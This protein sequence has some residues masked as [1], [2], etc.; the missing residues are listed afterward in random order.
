MI[1]DRLENAGQ[2]YRVCPWLGKAVEFAAKFDLSSTDG[3]YEVDGLDMYA[4]VMTYQTKTPR[5]LLFEVHRKYIDLQLVLG[6]VER[7]DVIN[8]AASLI[9]NK[10]YNVETDAEFYDE[11]S[12]YSSLIMSVGDFAVLYP[13]DAH[14]PGVSINSVG[15]VRKMVIKIKV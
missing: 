13:H 9:L 6:G 14:R 11:P 4:V 2:Y 15:N 5:A 1:Y 3:K 12:N 8:T 7:L 10:P